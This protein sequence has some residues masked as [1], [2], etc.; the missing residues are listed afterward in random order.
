MRLLF[1]AYASNTTT[2]LGILTEATDKRVSVHY[3]GPG[4]GSFTINRHSS[5]FAWCAPGNYIRAYIDSTSTAPIFGFFIESGQDRVISINEQGGQDVQRGGRGAL[6]YLERA[7]I[8]N[9]STFGRFADTSWTWTNATHGQIVKELIDDAQA[10]STLP[11]LTYDFTNTTE[12]GGG[13]WTTIT[14]TYELPVGLDLLQALQRQQSAGLVATMSPALVLSASATIGTDLSGTINF[15]A[16]VNISEE[17]T[18]DVLAS[19][20]K[21]RMLVQGTTTAGTA[22]FRWVT[23]S[24]TETALGDRREGFVSYQATADNATID[25][26][27]LQAIRRLKRRFDGLSVLGVLTDEFVPFTDYQPGDSIKVNV[28]GVWTNLVAPIT[29]I[30]LFDVDN[31]EADCALEFEDIAFEPLQLKDRSDITSSGGGS[32]GGGGATSGC[33]C[34]T[35]CPPWDGIGSPDPGED[36]LNELVWVGD[37]TTTSGTTDFPYTPGSLSIWVAGLNTTGYVTEDDPTTGALSL[38]FTPTGGQTV[39]ANYTAA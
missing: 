25:R 28:P 14:G 23:D 10:R 32:G 26:V 16:G 37:D 5:Q 13:T 33:D 8:D 35:C 21:S 11:L 1:R 17:V 6:V 27:G 4:T 31:G 39:R 9:S 29:S 34:A 20:A 12:S 18:R 19:A 15:Q 30:V 3:N 22:F 7:I 24:G 36:I 2:A 38:A